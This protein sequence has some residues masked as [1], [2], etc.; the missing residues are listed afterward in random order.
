MLE[1]LRI[2]NFSFLADQVLEFAPGLNVLT[3]ETGAGKSF[4]LKSLS[5]LLGESG[6][7]LPL[8]QDQKAVIEGIFVQGEQEW[9]IRR[10]LK[11]GRSR[12]FVNDQL[13]SSAKVKELGTKLLLAVSQHGQQALL[14]PN[15]ALHIVDNFLG[16]NELLLK[17]NELVKKILAL[18][19]QIQELNQTIGRLEEQKEFLLYQQTEIE[20]VNPK[21]GEEQELLAKIEALKQER[22]KIE[23]REKLLALLSGES[24]QNQYR[25]LLQN[26]EILELKDYLS[27]AEDFFY[28][29]QELEGILRSQGELD[30]A[31]LDQLESRLFVLSRLKRKL[32]KSLEEILTLKEDIEKNLSLL[33]QGELE[34]AQFNKQRQNLI[35]KLAKV[36]AELNQVRLKISQEIMDKLAKELKGLGF[37]P[38][39]RVIFSPEKKELVAGVEEL[40]FK[41]LWQ[42]NPGL[43]PQPLA[44]IASGGELSRLLLSLMSLQAEEIGTIVFD[45][46]DTG[47]GGLTLLKVGE[48]IKQLAARQQVILITHWPQLA[49]LADKHFKVEKKVKNQKTVISC[50][51]LKTK[52]EVKNELARMAGGDKQ[53]LQTSRSLLDKF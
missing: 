24:F 15:L 46:V 47:I 14:K 40:R 37:S 45:E 34:L 30:F 8:E 36:M 28:V 5:A 51:E 32:N 21:P 43:K 18:D 7:N 41:L 38:E 13:V 12:F 48:K 2:K 6:K 3:G 33:E 44:K 9:V 35:Q 4:L 42:P 10:E 11:P 49:A 31:D 23:A 27:Q 16:D 26:L 1:Y 50:T 19:K 20:K 17:R 29:L 52:A 39:T 25:E 22:N 53:I